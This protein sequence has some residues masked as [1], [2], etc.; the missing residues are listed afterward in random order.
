MARVNH[1]TRFTDK[2]VKAGLR[3]AAFHH[4]DSFNYALEELLPKAVC[5]M[6]MITVTTKEVEAREN[7]VQN[8]LFQQRASLWFEDVKLK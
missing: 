2:A 8:Q 5:N 4:V 3:N 7:Q 6:P 1:Q